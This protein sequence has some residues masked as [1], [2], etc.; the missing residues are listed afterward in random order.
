VN[1]ELRRN[2]WLELTLHRLLAMPL[3][4][5]LVLGLVYA[6]SDEDPR[7]SLATAAAAIAAG[8][9]GLWGARNA[10]DAVPGELRG[11]TWDAQRM[12]AIG[13][14]AMAWGK[15]LGATSF[16]WYGALLALA[17]LVLAAP[18]GW[19]HAPARV[20]M[21]IVAASLLAQA[22]A[23]LSGVAIARKG[24]ARPGAPSAWLL[25]LA[26]I[27]LWPAVA[28]FSSPLEPATWWRARYGILDFALASSAALAAWAVFG[29]YRAMCT[30]LQ[31]RTTP[32]AIA[33]FA[34]FVTAYLA[35]FLVAPGAEPGTG[36]DALIVCGFAVCA[37]LTYLMLFSEQASVTAAR[38]VQVRL[39]RGEWRRALEELPAWTATF[40]LAALFCLFSLALLEERLPLRSL[41]LAPA[42]AMLLLARDV[43]IYLVFA[44]ARRPRRVEAAAVFY[45]FLLYAVIPWLAHAAGLHALADLVLPPLLVKPGYA[46]VVAAGQAAIAFAFVA[47]RWRAYGEPR[48][49]P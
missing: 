17:V 22:T 8:L 18:R 39:A 13:P 14:W 24:L 7:S 10:A 46:T 21:L 32:W 9:A 35:G 4:L 38:R 2:L 23:A 37:A 40:A 20:A 5:A 43:A 31:V 16:A 44:F 33:A 34:L 27:L 30:E 36:H 48:P 15:L 49:Q 26:V 12:S 3:V 28:L 47:W 45:L 1:P 25:F 42:P 6:A 11:R 29:L 19:T 41:A